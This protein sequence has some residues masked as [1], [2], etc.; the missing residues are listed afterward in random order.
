MGEIF[1]VG[2]HRVRHGDV[3]D[4]LG[5]LLC[6]NKADYFYS[7]PPWG[8]GNLKYWQTMNHK[9]N[10]AE[11]KDVNLATF[12]DRVIEVSI[13]HTTDDAVIFFEY[14][15]RW[16]DQF[17]K[18]AEEHGLR[19]I[20]STEM[21]YGS[22]DNPVMS[23]VFDKKG[24]HKPPE[25]YQS[26]VYHTK[27]YKSLLAVMEPYTAS[28]GSILDPCCGLGYTAKY[29]VE[30]NLTFYGNELNMKRLERTIERLRAGAAR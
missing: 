6:G 13:D 7:D 5:E 19:H 23:I 30:H 16:H 1:Q 17:C 12:L 22:A 27:G 2:P 21:V 8:E 20:V 9:M 28:G 15:C 18:V 24:T 29:A 3:Y 14:G 10:G 4:D 25:G 11:K 26:R